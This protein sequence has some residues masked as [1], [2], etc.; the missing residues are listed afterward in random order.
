MKQVLFGVLFMV[1]CSGSWAVAQEVLYYPEN[2]TWEDTITVL[3]GVGFANSPCFLV[4][5][6]VSDLQMG[7][8]INVCHYEGLLSTPCSSIDTF[9]FKI[10][11]NAPGEYTFY[12]QLNVNHDYTLPFDSTCTETIGIDS[13]VINVSNPLTAS[14]FEDDGLVIYPNPANSVVRLRDKSSTMQVHSV[15]VIDVLGRPCWSVSGRAVTDLL[16]V[17]D[18]PNGI[19]MVTLTD[20]DGNRHTQRLVVQH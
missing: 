8:L 19:Y 6:E 9:K 1:E 7:Y 13:V 4:D 5:A 12:C 18:W 15:S 14:L 10:P 3:C 16:S 11:D 2:P 20:E 17:S